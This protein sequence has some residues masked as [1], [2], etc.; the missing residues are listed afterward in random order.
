MRTIFL[1]QLLNLIFKLYFTSICCDQGRAVRFESKEA[2][3]NVIGFFVYF[4]QTRPN[5]FAVDKKN[6][7]L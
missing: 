4:L 2:I 5:F 1:C 7:S 3:E 6:L